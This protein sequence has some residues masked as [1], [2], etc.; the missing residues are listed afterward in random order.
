MP[1]I[2]NGDMRE[3]LDFLVEDMFPFIKKLFV[4]E[5]IQEFEEKCKDLISSDT[6]KKLLV[7]K[8]S[9]EQ[10]SRLAYVLTNR[11]VFRT[12]T[13]IQYLGDAISREA[14]VSWQRDLRMYEDEVDIC[15]VAQ[16]H[17]EI[18][19]LKELEAEW[20]K[21][22]ILY[23][24]EDYAQPDYIK[25]LTDYEESFMLV[26]NTMRIMRIDGNNKVSLSGWTPFSSFE[27]LTLAD[28]LSKKFYTLYNFCEAESHADKD[29]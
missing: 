28:R 21:K 1:L 19:E 5:S 7:K 12:Q 26:D 9:D 18:E 8:F 17:T 24:L 14:L 10:I 16:K 13:Y 3:L 23:C 22:D 25:N 11:L 15:I 2:I 20:I 6:R 4:R 29:E 27:V